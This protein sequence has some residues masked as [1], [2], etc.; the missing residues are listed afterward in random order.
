MRV[1]WTSSFLGIEF[2]AK[3][4]ETRCSYVVHSDIDSSNG[5]ILPFR[6]VPV[7]V[8]RCAIESVS[9]GVLPSFYRIPKGP[10]SKRLVSTK[11]DKAGSPILVAVYAMSFE[12]STPVSDTTYFIGPRRA[13]PQLSVTWKAVAM[14]LEEMAERDTRLNRGSGR[15]PLPHKSLTRTL[16]HF[17]C[18]ISAIHGKKVRL[19]VLVALGRHVGL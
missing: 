6:G 14:E 16:S 13:D 4:D 9:P 11:L 19:T 7:L 3:Y 17:P 10:V 15:S 18:Y 2:T 5:S 1:L 12:S 8:V